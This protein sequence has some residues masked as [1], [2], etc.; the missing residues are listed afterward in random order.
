MLSAAL[1]AKPSQTKSKPATK[2]FIINLDD[3][4]NSEEALEEE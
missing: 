3:S 2:E 1:A 4:S